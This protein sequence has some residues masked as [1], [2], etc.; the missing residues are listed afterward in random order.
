MYE[1]IVLLGVIIVVTLLIDCKLLV[2]ET[3]TEIQLPKSPSQSIFSFITIIRIKY[4]LV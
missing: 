4:L 1:L 2:N 3:R